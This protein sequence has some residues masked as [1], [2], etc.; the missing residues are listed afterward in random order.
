[1]LPFFRKIRKNLIQSTAINKYLIYAVGEILLVVVGILIALQ[2]NNWNEVRKLRNNEKVY[3]ARMYEDVNTMIQNSSYFVNREDFLEQSLMALR[4]IERCELDSTSQYNLEFTLA[5]HQ[6]L[7]LFPIE[8]TTYDEMLSIGMIAQLS[9]DS[10]KVQLSDL[11]SAIEASQNLLEYFRT[12]L[13]R[14]SEVIMKHVQFTIPDQSEYGD[15]MVSD[16]N[17]ETLCNNLEFRNAMVEVYDARNDANTSTNWIKKRL[18]K[19]EELLE[20]ELNG[21]K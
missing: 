13:G 19:V 8:R 11:F 7:A 14:A 1:M 17:F 15:M 12:E 18:D 6:V 4:A 20:E 3:L 10:L 9:N 5:T 16:L 2:V 21:S